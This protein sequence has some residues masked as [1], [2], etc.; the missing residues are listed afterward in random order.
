MKKAKKKFTNIQANIEE[1]KE[2]ESD[3]S[4]SDVESHVD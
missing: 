3:L 2:E 1:R 4:Y